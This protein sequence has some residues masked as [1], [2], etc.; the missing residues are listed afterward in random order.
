MILLVFSETSLCV[1]DYYE[2][3]A[4][5]ARSLTAGATMCSALPLKED[6]DFIQDG[7]MPRPR[8]SAF[9]GWGRRHKRGGI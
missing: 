8:S 7:S 2:I 6:P 4:V 9:R 3:P 1:T 5:S